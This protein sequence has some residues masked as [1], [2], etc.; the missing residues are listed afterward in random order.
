M[1]TVMQVITRCFFISARARFA[2]VEA[3]VAAGYPLEATF[4]YPCIV[5]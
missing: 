5:R 4:T 1:A 3:V 2:C